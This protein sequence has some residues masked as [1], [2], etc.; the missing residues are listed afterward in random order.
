[1]SGEQESL[2]RSRVDYGA[3]SASPLDGVAVAQN[4]TSGESFDNV[5][6][7]RRRLGVSSAAFLIFNRVIGTGIF[8]TPSVI[9]SGSGSAGV[10]LVMWVVGALIA[11]AGTTVYVELGTGLPRS[12]GEKNYLEFIY[13]RPKYMITCAYFVYTFISGSSAS[14]GIVFGEYVLRAL[15]L[16]PTPTSWPLSLTQIIALLVLTFSLLMSGVFSRAGVRVLNVLGSFKLFILAAIAILGLLSLAGVSSLAVRDDYEQP[17]NFAS[18]SALWKG[19]KTDVNSLVTALYNVIWSFIGYSNANYALSEVKDPVRTIKRSA[20]LAIASVA[21]VYLLVNIG[22]LGVVSR[23]DILGSRQIVAALFFRNLFGPA[24]DRILS[25][26]IALSSLGNILAVLFT[27]GRVVQELAREGILPFSA[28]LSSNRPFGAPLS[29]L[30]VLYG[31]SLLGVVAPPPGDAY[32]FLLSMSGYSLTL[33]NTFVSFGLIMLHTARPSWNW[34]PPFR[35]SAVVVWAFFASNVFLAI[36]PLIPPAPGKGTFETIPYYMHVF[37]TILASQLGVLYWAVFFRWLP[38]RGGYDL[39]S[40]RV[41]QEDGVSRTV[42]VKIPPAPDCTFDDIVEPPIVNELSKTQKLEARI[43]ELEALLQ[44]KDGQV[45]S[46]ANGSPPFDADPSTTV[47][48]A[49]D[50]PKSASSGLEIVF[51][52][53]APGL[54]GPLLLQHL[55]EVFFVFHPHAKRVIHM[56]S[57]MAAL[58]TGNPMHPRYPSAPL[59]HAICALGALYT[60]AVTSPPLPS[61]LSDESPDEIFT[62]RQRL[63]ERRPDSFAEQQAKLARDTADQMESVGDRLLE[64]LQARTILT[65]FYWYVVLWVGYDSLTCLLV[66]L[67]MAGVPLGLNVCPPFHSITHSNRPASILSPAPTVIEDETRRN[68]FW[69]AYSTERLHGCSNGWAMSLD[70]QD[71]SQLLPRMLVSPQNRQWAQTRDVL[72]EHPLD[73][74][75]SFVLWIKGTMMISRAKMFNTSSDESVDPRGSPAFT[76]IDNIA[77]NFRSSFPAHLRHPIVENV[78]DQHLYVACL[79]PLLTT[80]LLHDPHADVRRSGCISALRIV[81]AARSILDLAYEVCSTSFDVTLLDPFCSFCWFVASR[82]LVRF[83]QA[84][85]DVNNTDQVSTLRAELEFMQGA[86][87]R[88]GQR[89]PLAFRYGKMLNDLIAN[90]CGPST[91]AIIELNFPR[92]TDEVLDMGAWFEESSSL[93]EPLGQQADPRS[94]MTVG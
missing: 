35:A 85:M 23:N 56:P 42:F 91:Q 22:Y 70:D 8:A 73:Q 19:S 16:P 61:F 82:V 31:I 11:G 24:T 29:A 7:E 20:P 5:P 52:G 62:Q 57:F 48:V 90:R 72:L 6:Q 33:V 15:D 76:E 68:L 93:H 53:Y 84:A 26:C 32:L 2:L 66:P 37:V 14:N 81:T 36:A 39:K 80:I 78:V 51:P 21:T 59:L 64:V 54:P 13:R 86:I 25:G 41:V 47:S 67:S 44:Q 1:M 49:S 58:A 27:Q 18:W 55:V 88:I 40:E 79:M 65:Y 30:L 87:M 34:N 75:D 83:L 45:L 43:L 17:D 28:F 69:L 74:T 63:R 71:V 77:S 46:I 92:T 94:F 9:L 3:V 38:R 50:S 4:D 10:A 89:V 60:A 12:G